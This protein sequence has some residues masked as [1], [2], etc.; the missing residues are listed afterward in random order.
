MTDKSCIEMVVMFCNKIRVKTE[1]LLS[2]E[3]RERGEKETAIKQ[4]NEE[5]SRIRGEVNRL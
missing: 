1:N 2:L 3:K 5:N 4:N